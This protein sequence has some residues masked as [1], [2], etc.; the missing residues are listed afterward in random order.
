MG[1]TIHYWLHCQRP[2][3]GA[4][5]QGAMGLT[6]HYSLHLPG[7]NVAEARG[8]VEK[9]RRHALTL[10]FAKVGSV[11]DLDGPASDCDRQDKGG[12]NQ[13]MLIQATRWIERDSHML[14]V[15]PRRLIAFVTSPGEGSEPANFGL[16]LYPATVEG[17]AQ[18][19]G[20]PMKTG[21]AGW[22]WSSF[23]KTQYASNPASG[24]VENFLRAH[25]SIVRLL[26]HAAELGILKDVTDEGG[27]WQG[28]DIK[29]L[30][31]VVGQW[32]AMIAGV[33]GSMKDAMGGKDVRAEITNYPNYEHLEAEGRRED[34]TEDDSGLAPE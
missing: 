8:L 18:N 27:Y 25:L 29:A 17:S 9:L 21:L 26:D 28:R 22:R 13:W 4:V 1:R 16:C 12:A 15:P 30:A 34:G 2:G 11:I 10:P 32:N 33:V 19:G 23:C 5:K 3:A 20:M 24:D 7:R 31:Q 6:I 14:P